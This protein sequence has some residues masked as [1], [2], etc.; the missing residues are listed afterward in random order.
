M[1]AYKVPYEQLMVSQTRLFHNGK[2][3]FFISDA[4]RAFVYYM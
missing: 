4:W 1:D 2:Q 3:V